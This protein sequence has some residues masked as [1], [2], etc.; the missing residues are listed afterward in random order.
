VGRLKE[1]LLIA[2]STSIRTTPTSLCMDGENKELS[3]L[4]AF[5]LVATVVYFGS[6][7]GP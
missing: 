2:D 1:R 3:L 5:S 6:W 4:V 7:R